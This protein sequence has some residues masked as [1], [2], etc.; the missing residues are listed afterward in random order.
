MSA[1]EVIE[2]IQK[3]PREEQQK[4]ADYLLRSEA[5]A[6]HGKPN[7]SK[8]YP[9]VSLSFTTSRS[10]GSSSPVS[11]T[12]NSRAFMARFDRPPRSEATMCRRLPTT[13]GDT[14]S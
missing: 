2:Q 14:C 9:C 13:S 10:P 8:V 6:N 3:L 1:T 5:Q 11:S 4:V 12:P 7:A